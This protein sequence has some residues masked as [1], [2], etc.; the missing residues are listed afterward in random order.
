MA[1]VIHLKDNNC[2]VT[3][4]IKTETQYD[5]LSAIANI[6]VEELIKKNPD[7]LV[8]PQSLEISEDKIEE[9]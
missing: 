2:G 6:T 1:E 3:K 9:L 4:K 5:D 7:V 8:F